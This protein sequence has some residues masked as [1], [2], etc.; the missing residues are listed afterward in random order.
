[1]AHFLVE[2]VDTGDTQA[3]EAHRGAHIGYRK[4]L[5]TRLALAGP[6]MD[7]N[8]KPC[9]SVVIVEAGSRAEAEH[10]ALQDPY[11]MNGVLKLVSLRGYRIAAMN[12]PDKNNV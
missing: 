10:W 12:P 8:G 1:M 11:I 6:L 2:Y 9:G 3:R 7:E 4:E 5:G